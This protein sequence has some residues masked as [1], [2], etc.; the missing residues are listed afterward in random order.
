VCTLIRVRFALNKPSVSLFLAREFITRALLASKANLT[1]IV[2]VLTNKG[3]GTADGFNV[4]FAFLDVPVKSR[5]FYTAEVTPK[6]ED[7]RS[8]V[9]LADFGIGR[10]SLHTNRSVRAKR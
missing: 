6:A 5:V 7:N 8:E 10:N 4:N 3:I 9:Y 1:E 2:D